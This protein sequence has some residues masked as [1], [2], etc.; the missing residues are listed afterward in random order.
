MKNSGR[1]MNRRQFIQNASSGGAA[2]VLGA[3]VLNSPLA[4]A[5]EKDFNPFAYDIERFRKTDPKLLAY[6]PV[7]K[8]AFPGADP[9]RIAAGPGDRLYVAFRNGVAVLDS[10]G[11]RVSEVPVSEPV[12]CVAVSAEGTV[13]AGIR[14]HVEVFDAKGA[15]TAT[16]A[17]PGKKAWITG[18]AVAENEVFAADSGSRLV[19]RFDRSGKVLGKV[20]EKNREKN[21]PGLVVP[22]PYLDVKLGRDGLLRVNNT[23]RH[24]VELYTTAGDLELAWGKPSAGIE[25]FC[26]CCNPIGFALLPD[27]SHITCEK[28]LPRVKVYSAQGKFECVVAGTESFPESAG[29]GPKA[30]ADCTLGGL[31]ATVDSQGRI[32]ILDLVTANIHMMQK[33]AAA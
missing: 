6:E 4:R 16:W 23:G 30:A 29:L 18:L 15:R 25:G 11:A 24:Q 33:K 5:A 17:A 12:R 7:A 8:R 3:A 10:H 20:G 31:D 13:Y 19:W 32:Y 1:P 27:G 9:R 26:G 21:V 14:D 2:A 22:S 28:G